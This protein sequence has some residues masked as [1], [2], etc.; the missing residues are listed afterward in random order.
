MNVIFVNK[1]LTSEQKEVI[2]KFNNSADFFSAKREKR[3]TTIPFVLTKGTDKLL[4]V[5]P[6]IYQ[7]S[8]ETL[9][10]II[11]Y[12]KKNYEKVIVIDNSGIYHP[13][14]DDAVCLNIYSKLL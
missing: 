8:Y 14:L 7:V 13:D 1:K 9:T 6:Y 4:V 5:T 12:I 10:R 11:N 3:L 2:N